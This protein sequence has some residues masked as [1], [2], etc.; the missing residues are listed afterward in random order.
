MRDWILIADDL[1]DLAPL[2]APFR[3]MTTRDYVLRPGLLAGARPKIINLSRSYTYQAD[4]YY[5]SLLAEAR[6]HRVVPSVATLIDLQDRSG[7]EEALPDL[8]EALHKDAAK[9]NTPIPERLLVCFGETESDAFRKFGRLLFDWYRA[10]A[11][12]V[13]VG[14]N[15]APGVKIK[16]LKIAPFTSL[17]GDELQFFVASLT[18]Y[19]GR[20][21]KSPKTR[22]VAKHSIAVLYDPNEVMPPSDVETLKYF[23]RQAE[24][25]GVE[26]EPITRRDL[27]RLAEFDALFIRE[28]TSITNHTY[29][30]ARRAVA[31]GMPVID[32][33]T[34]MMRCTNKV[35]LWERLVGAGL[36]AP[37]TV[38]IQEKARLEEV[39]DIL[40]FPLVLKIPDGSF[41]RGVKKAES[42]SEL[43]ELTNA[44]LEES[45]LVIAQ[46]YIPT[47]FDW[48]IGV[49][50]Q[51]PLF[52]CRYK[53]ARG[54]WQIIRHRED[55]GATEGG[56]EAVAIAEAPAD[57][58]DIG[59]RAANLIGDGL[60]GVDIK[61]GPN[62]PTVIEIN[63][64]PNLDHGVED[65][66][67]KAALWARLTDWFVR[68][69]TV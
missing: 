50:D 48:R 33:P 20:V 22:T 60:Y 36:P 39:A 54:H 46:E 59:V 62:G 55:G 45:D 66:I 27:S 2:G 69:L 65:A 34:S 42:M 17:R 30:F 9:A 16:R 38:I 4:G 32:D 18:K 35:Y 40:G 5:G 64:N 44:F 63:D 12:I 41:S 1:R 28:T 47:S 26:I 24:K 67:E 11:I 7:A 13:T 51:R 49:L 52:A 43:V 56:A 61:V 68:R 58:V 29:R 3:M 31:E 57:V 53:M 21:W 19:S 10:P 25:D 8:E 23:A 6:G 14:A 15:G 37:R